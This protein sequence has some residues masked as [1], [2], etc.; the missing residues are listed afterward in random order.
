MNKFIDSER[1]KKVR[2]K[3]KLTQNELGK[4]IGISQKSVSHLESGKTKNIPL[5]YLLFLFQKNIS[6]YWIM[7]WSDEMYISNHQKSTDNK[8]ESCSNY[9]EFENQK[10]KIEEMSKQIEELKKDRTDL[11][12][13]LTRL[14]SKEK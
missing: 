1:V 10:I 5:E 7:G 6:V 14:S 8:V 3:L 2:K 4:L 11:M 9:Q 12:R 13:L